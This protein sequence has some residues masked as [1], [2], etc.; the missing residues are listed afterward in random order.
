MTF[1]SIPLAHTAPP[2]SPLFGIDGSICRTI[3][4]AGF[5]PQIAA[6][7][8]KFGIQA[9]ASQKITA[10]MTPHSIITA[11]IAGAV[12]TD[13]NSVTIRA[14]AGAMEIPIKAAAP[15]QSQFP[16]KY[17]ELSLSTKITG[18]LFQGNTKLSTEYYPQTTAKNTAKQVYQFSCS[19]GKGKTERL[20]GHADYA[21]TVKNGN[22]TTGNCAASVQLQIRHNNI[23]YIVKCGI[24]RRF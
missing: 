11:K 8:C 20:T 10:T 21:I 5:T 24:N 18:T 2:E 14:D 4:Q 13:L 6:G 19:A 12:S 1:F 7:P 23:H 9:L 22:R 3:T 15:S 16:R 17:Y